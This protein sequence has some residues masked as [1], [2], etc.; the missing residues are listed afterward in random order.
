MKL[1]AIRKASNSLLPIAGVRQRSSSMPI[2]VFKVAEAQFH[3]PAAPIEL[4][5][6]FGRIG[7]GVE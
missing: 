3:V 6:L 1:W 5:D 4:C 7:D 2:V